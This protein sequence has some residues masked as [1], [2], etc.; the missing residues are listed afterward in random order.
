LKKVL[1]GN[2]VNRP[3]TAEITADDR[4]SV[5]VEVNATV[6]SVLV[7]ADSYYSGWKA[8]DNGVPT[9]V[10]IADGLMKAVLLEPGRHKVAF[11]YVPRSYLVGL[12]VSFYTF[13]VLLALVV[14]PHLWNS[15][16]QMR[17]RAIIQ[18]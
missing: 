16:N 14:V 1:A 2:I 18:S 11:K 7:F 6:P 5:L 3:G 9:H 15:L 10:F 8:T 4:E 13:F 12:M 17:R